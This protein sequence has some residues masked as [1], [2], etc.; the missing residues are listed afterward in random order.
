ML[1]LRGGT[2]HGGREIGAEHGGPASRHP[3]EDRDQ[4]DCPPPSPR[5]AEAAKV[6][7]CGIEKIHWFRSLAPKRSSRQAAR[8]SRCDR[9]ALLKYQA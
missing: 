5:A 3:T 2:A 6:W 4:A 8:T 9:K 7:D 1:P